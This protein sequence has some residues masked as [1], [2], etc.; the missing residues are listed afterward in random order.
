MRL[1]VVVSILFVGAGGKIK[2]ETNSVNY[3]KTI[4]N[5]LVA[6]FPFKSVVSDSD[7]EHVSFDEEDWHLVHDTNG[8]MHLVC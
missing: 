5:I 7:G 3:M 2:N 8:K 1:I 4:Y 6:A